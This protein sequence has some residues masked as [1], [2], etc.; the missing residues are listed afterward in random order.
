MGVCIYKYVFI[1]INGM[2]EHGTIVIVFPLLYI[3]HLFNLRVD[4]GLRRENILAEFLCF[5]VTL[6]GS[7]H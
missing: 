7:P 4:T 3:T 1:H 2:E 6:A 5:T